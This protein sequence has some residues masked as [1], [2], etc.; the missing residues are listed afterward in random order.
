M[1]LLAVLA[2]ACFST[3]LIIRV[4]DPLIPQIARDLA[5]L[6]ATV[7]LIA[8]AFAFPYAFGQPMLGPLADALGKARIIKACLAV[9]AAGMAL[10]ALAPTVETLFAARI[11]TGL[12]AGG[13]IPV[14]LALVGDR[15][16]MHERQVALSRLLAAMLLGQVVGAIGSGVI[17]TAFGW[18]SVMVV[19]AAIV[20]AALVLTLAKLEPRRDAVRKPFSFTSMREGYARILANPRAKICFTAVFV[21]G[22]CILGLV[23]YLAVLLEQ[24]GAGSTREAG[25]VL[26]GLGAGGILFSALVR[27]LLHRLGG[28]MNMMRAGGAVAGL[29]LALYAAA[30]AVAT[31][32]AAFVVLGLGFYML[33]NSLQTQATELAPAARGASVALH[34]FSFFAGQAVGPIAYRLG[35]GAVGP[36]LTILAAAATMAAIGFW[37]AH[38]LERHPAAGQS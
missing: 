35:L 36:V 6:P 8:S 34:A 13:V 18:R 2:L 1:P 11:L 5:S 19:G 25:I 23:P 29:G 26:A 10:A 15:F 28:Q 20:G 24:R 14:G 31:E 9:V 4:T 27:Y 33:H 32:A 22:V 3:S 17:G 16:E 37:T 30:P 38:Y 21:E 12:A 7:A